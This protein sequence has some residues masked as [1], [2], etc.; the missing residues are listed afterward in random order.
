LCTY[1]YLLATVNYV[2]IAVESDRILMAPVCTVRL[3][4]LW[5][6]RG[7]VL[8]EEANMPVT[9]TSLFI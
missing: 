7:V 4:T 5:G 2:Q 6:T 3:F 1:E 9:V 8:M